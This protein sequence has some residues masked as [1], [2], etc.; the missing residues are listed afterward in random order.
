MINFS[1]PTG[2][3]DDSLKHPHIATDAFENHSHLSKFLN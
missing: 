2:Q 1:R 3:G